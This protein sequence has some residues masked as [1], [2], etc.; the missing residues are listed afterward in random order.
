VEIKTIS[1][2]GLKR[3]KLDDLPTGLDFL[4]EIKTIPDWG[5]K[6]RLGCTAALT[7]LVVEMKT[8]PAW[9]LKRGKPVRVLA[10]RD[11]RIEIKAIPAKGTETS[12]VLAVPPK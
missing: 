8:I 7:R 3:A 10:H 4:V 12:T 9:G 1:D 5:L 6:L 11:E 2:W